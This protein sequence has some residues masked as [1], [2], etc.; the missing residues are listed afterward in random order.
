MKDSG[1]LTR[2]SIGAR[3]KKARLLKNLTQ[4][5]L[6][7]KVSASERSLRNLESGENTQ[8]D[9]FFRVLQELGY[10]DD[11]S[12]LLSLP[13]PNTIEEHQAISQGST[14]KA[15]AGEGAMTKIPT[16]LNVLGEADGESILLGKL[17]Y[18]E[19][20]QSSAFQWSQEALDRH[21]EWSPLF[22]PLTSKL[23]VSGMREKDLMGLPGLIHDALPDGWGMLLMDRAFGQTGIPRHRISPLLRLA[24]LANRCWGALSFVPEWGEDIDKRQRV[25]IGAL[26]QEAQQVM[27]G[28]TDR[29]SQ[30]LL[31]AGG[32]PHGARPKVMVAVSDDLTQA[33]VGQED[34]PP[35]YRHVLIKFSGDGEGPTH[36]VLEFCYTEAARATGIH[37]APATL[38]EAG[39]RAGLCVDRFDRVDG[40]RRHVHSMAGILHTTHRIANADWLQVAEI[41]ER[42][43]GGQADLEQAFRRAVFNAVF[44]VRDD[45]TKNIAFMRHGNTWGLS[46]AFDIAYCDG[47]G[48]YHTM[49][50]AEHQG[51]DVKREDLVRLAGPFGVT[52]PEVDRIIE[53]MRGQRELMLK[54]AR[55]L[56]VAKP[57]LAQ[58]RALL[59]DIDKTLKPRVVRAG[60]KL[61]K[62]T[63]SNSPSSH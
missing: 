55:S 31:V 19:R 33:L 46:P 28:D 52:E 43:E 29:V 42:L 59:K 56:G 57:I 48:G 23:W 37:T 21:Q 8:T 45:H 34:L 26:A 36:P 12:V 25:A 41:L 44:C 5:Q 58:V 2:K 13:K 38:I 10:L 7:E 15:P 3:L 61:A 27:H 54:E 53:Q 11:L 1:A 18:I 22:M 4:A 51:R 35:G 30:A 17:S 24:F 40:Q 62:A 14:Q 6:A 63:P 9:V 49:T 50:Y 60:V 20:D 16:V 39:G 47:P 32:S